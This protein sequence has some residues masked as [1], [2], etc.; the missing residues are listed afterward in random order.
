MLAA[1]W[2]QC[3]GV[4]EN[5][6]LTGKVSR[7]AGLS[8]QIWSEAACRRDCVEESEVAGIIKHAAL[9]ALA[10]TVSQHGVRC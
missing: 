9:I 7:G 10:L 4:R 3:P 2:A 6:L 5:R 8:Q 1:A